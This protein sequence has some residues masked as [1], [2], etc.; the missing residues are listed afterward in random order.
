MAAQN[1]YEGIMRMLLGR[2]YIDPDKADGGG[3]TPLC[4]AALKEHEG[5]VR[6]LLGRDDVSPDIRCRNGRT[7]LSLAA[8][9]G[10]EGVVRMLLGQSNVNPNSLDENGRPPLMWNFAWALGSGENASP[11]RRHYSRQSRLLRQNTALSCC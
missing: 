7:P 3:Q 1:G 11:A 4:W 9:Y 5:V 2:D 8:Q 6:L 10:H